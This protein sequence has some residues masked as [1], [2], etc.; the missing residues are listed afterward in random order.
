MNLL[1]F[2]GLLIPLLFLETTFYPFP[3]LMA[4]FVT[5]G[6]VSSSAKK[7]LL[8]LIVGFLFDILAGN[9]LGL[10]SIY[11]LLFL[12][13]M[14]KI[15]SLFPHSLL[16]KMIVF[17]ILEMGFFFLNEIYPSFFL[18]I[19]G[20]IIFGLTNWLFSSWL[21]K[22]EEIQLEFDLISSLPK[23]IKNP[24]VFKHRYFIRKKK[25]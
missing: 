24:L 11:L 9:N 14:E 21:K 4:F 7:Y 23:E 16:L 2:F 20:I 18:I 25:R 5:A 1:L 12:L 22:E 19:T 13:V 3:F 17:T 15:F 10:T 6:I 8:A